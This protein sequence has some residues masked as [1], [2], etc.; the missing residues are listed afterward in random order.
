MYL[1]IDDDTPAESILNLPAAQ[2][3]RRSGA[4]SIVLTWLGENPHANV[5]HLRAAIQSADSGDWRHDDGSEIQAS[6]DSGLYLFA[7][8]EKRVGAKLLDFKIRILWPGTDDDGNRY[9]VIAWGEDNANSINVY[10]DDDGLGGGRGLLPF[11]DENNYELLFRAIQNGDKMLFVECDSAQ[12]EI[13]LIIAE[14]GMEDPGFTD[15]YTLL[16]EGD[17]TLTDGFDFAVEIADTWE[18]FRQQVRSRRAALTE[19]L[20]AQQ[21]A[22]KQQA[23]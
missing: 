13:E 2:G 15:R 23:G 18:G 10:Y 1:N 19:E 6:P 16:V 11:D 14:E 8:S 20:K 4:A 21:M 17:G 5:S 3:W 7:T 9:A 22:E 12:E